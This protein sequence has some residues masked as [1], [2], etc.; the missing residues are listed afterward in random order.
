MVVP[1][2]RKQRIDFW[3]FAALGP[4]L[5]ADQSSDHSNINVIKIYITQ[6]RDM[7]VF[8]ALNQ[9]SDDIRQRG[10][11]VLQAAG[12]ED[13]IIVSVT[14]IAEV[15]PLAEHRLSHACRLVTILAGPGRRVLVCAGTDG[16][17]R[18]KASRYFTQFRLCTERKKS[19]FRCYLKSTVPCAR[20]Y[21]EDV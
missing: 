13:Q 5:R 11:R 10:Q 14:P 18:C 3:R 12:V 15:R 19:A 21:G 20:I 9:C 7:L 6:L 1:V 16:T 2:I 8:V 4:V 17:H